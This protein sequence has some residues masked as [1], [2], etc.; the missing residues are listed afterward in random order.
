VILSDV[1]LLLAGLCLLFV[2]GEALVRGAVSLANRLRLPHLVIGLT[3][4]GFGTSMPELLVSLQAAV[5]GHSDIAVGNVVGSNVANILLILGLSAVIAP[6]LVRIPGIARDVA[7]MMTAAVVMLGLAFVGGVGP[8]LG[9]AMVAALC[10]YMVYVALAGRSETKRAPVPKARLPA[11]I[12]AAALV[13]G[14]AALLAGAHLLVTSS[15]S[16]ARAVGVSEAVIGLT[17]VAVGTSLPELAAS[18]VAA[19]RG[20]SEVAVGNVVGSNIFNILG[21]L[22]LTAI[23]RPIRISSEMATFNVPTMVAISAM[24]AVTLLALGK[25]NRS[26]AAFFL[27]G[28]AAYVVALF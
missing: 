24:L 5:D 10:A 9:M 21:I 17:I 27:V 4:V 7:M 15:I 20:Q 22:G 26:V 16:I 23:V 19:Y 3:V 13:G 11:V 2:G 6:V 25:L 14:L 18:I 28:Y 1:G 8:V 12:E